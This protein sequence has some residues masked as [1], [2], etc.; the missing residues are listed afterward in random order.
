MRRVIAFGLFVAI[1]AVTTAEE[2]KKKAA[3]DPVKLV[4]SWQIT[5]G[6][7][8]GTKSSDDAIKGVVKFTKDKIS[9]GEG[10]MSF[11]FSYTLDT[12]VSP[13][14][15][16]MEMTKSPFNVVMK[17]K[18][19]ISLDGEEMKLCYGTEDRPAKFDGEK[20]MLFVMKKKKA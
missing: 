12:K 19:I 15:I 4:G 10:D 20:A 18:G 16:D 9:M 11:E 7:K 6:T 2:E 13:V 14:A 3:L 8:N 5:A 17:A 1:T